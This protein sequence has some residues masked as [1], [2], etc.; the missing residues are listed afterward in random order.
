M[1]AKVLQRHDRNILGLVCL[2]MV[3]GVSAA[4]LENGAA[5]YYDHG[6]YSCH[7]YNGTGRT[8]LANNVSG[9]LIKLSSK[10]EFFSS[11]LERIRADCPNPQQ[12]IP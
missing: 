6:C 8:P 4:D 2:L 12:R 10:R 5:V 7:G 1:I 9:I 11:L 3:S